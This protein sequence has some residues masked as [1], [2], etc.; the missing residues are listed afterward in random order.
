MRGGGGGE[1]RSFREAF[2]F[3][4]AAEGV[5]LQAPAYFP[6]EEWKNCDLNDDSDYINNTYL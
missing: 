6:G 3:L 4:L 5:L 1:K 2:H